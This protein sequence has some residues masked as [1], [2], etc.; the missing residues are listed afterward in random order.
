MKL[1]KF[2]QDDYY[3]YAGVE[4]EGTDVAMITETKKQ[5]DEEREI[6]IDTHGFHIFGLNTVTMEESY[7]TI[8][9]SY[10]AAGLMILALP[11]SE[12]F[13]FNMEKM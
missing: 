12:I 6:I 10:I 7:R 13:S 5:G 3:Q 4:E 9:C 2:S 1:S 11:D 8:N